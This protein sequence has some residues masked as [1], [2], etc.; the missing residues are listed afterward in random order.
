MATWKKIVF[1]V[2]LVSFIGLS[3]SFTFFSIA[4]DTFEFREQENIGDIEGLSGWE[5]YGFNGNSDTTEVHI[6]YVRNEDGSDPD[7]TKPVIAVGD[8]TIVSDEY[9]Q[10]I[11]IG[12][13]VQYIA[14]S[15]FYYCKQL[16]AVFVDEEN[17]YFTSVDG[18]LFT[19]DMKTLILHPILNGQWKVEQGL[20]DTADTFV[21]P[22]GVE[23]IE[24]FSFY[25][26]TDLVHLTFPSTLKTIG[27]MS[28]FGC[29]NMW[30]IWLPEGLESIGADAFSYCGSISPVMYIPSTV[31]FIDD[32][33]FFSCGGIST[34]YMGAENEESIEFGESWLP[35]NVLKVLFHVAI[36][37]E[38]G[39]TLEEAQAEKVRLDS[40]QE[41]EG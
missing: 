7:E 21:I 41:Q 31:N 11:Y 34:M 26:N 2:V 23:N 28:F 17:P 37:P 36:T 15:A 14:D 9:V 40:L 1:V 10:F 30:S 20:A 13:D 8:F 6:D 12:K 25:K 39:K 18:V 16:R 35:K 3:L 29:G 38:Y 4:R 32:Y 24:S 19:K 33:A 22:D 5:F 27:T